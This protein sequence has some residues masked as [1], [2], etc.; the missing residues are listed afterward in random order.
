M[1]QQV[2]SR[3]PVPA[4]DFKK[5]SI[6]KRPSLDDLTL[7]VRAKLTLTFVPPPSLPSV[8][9]DRHRRVPR[10]R[11]GSFIENLWCH[12][13]TLRTRHGSR[14][15]R[16]RVSSELTCPPARV[17]LTGRQLASPPCQL[18]LALPLRRSTKRVHQC[19]LQRLYR[20]GQRTY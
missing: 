4:L 11:R 9:A 3:S 8:P 14:L 18:V 12:S 15:G 6:G 19:R 2:W 20:G 10:A 5:D 1:T 17:P 16:F 13:S 7:S